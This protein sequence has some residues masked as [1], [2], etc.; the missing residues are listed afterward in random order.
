MSEEQTEPSPSPEIP[1]AVVQARSRFSLVWLIPIVAALIGA[2]LAYKAYSEQGPSITIT[3]A[4]A[5]GLEAG[6]R[7]GRSRRSRSAE[8]SL[9]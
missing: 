8:A 6:K 9:M 4:T 5:E 2:W 1:Q 3:F 7:L